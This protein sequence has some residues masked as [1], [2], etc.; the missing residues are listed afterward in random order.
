MLGVRRHVAGPETGLTVQLTIAHIRCYHR[1]DRKPSTL[2]R[3]CFSSDLYFSTSSPRTNFSLRSM[4]TSVHSA[5]SKLAV[6]LST[7][8]VPPTMT[9]VGR[10]NLTQAYN[11]KFH[12]ELVRRLQ[13]IKTRRTVLGRVEGVGL[14][15]LGRLSYPLI[16]SGKPLLTVCSSRK[17]E[18]AVD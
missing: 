13:A 8:S 2:P 1:A 10:E 3:I 6:K 16:I 5:V 15:A 12:K 18:E 4:F 9:P 7:R 17:N 14:R 11:P